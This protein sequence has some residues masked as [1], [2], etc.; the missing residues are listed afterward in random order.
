VRTH[1]ADTPAL[2]A[3]RRAFHTLKGSG[4]MVG[5]ARLGEAAW[6]VEQTMN[7][8][9]QDERAATP[10]LL[11]L[12]FMAH[13]YFADNVARLKEGGIAS[14]E[15]ALIE[16]ATQVRRGEPLAAQARSLKV[17]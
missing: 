2:I 17:S 16:L 9:L 3:I 7:H 10:D 12:V 13:D 11:S 6:A 8:W 15:G 14:D 5:L 1:P 4:R